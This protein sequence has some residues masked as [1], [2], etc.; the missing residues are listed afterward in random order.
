MP[1]P[2]CNLLHDWLRRTAAERPHAP[3]IEEDEHIT[4]FDQLYRQAEALA[5][6][7]IV[8]GLRPGD[9]VALRLSKTTSAAASVFACLL[10][11]AVY[12]P[13]HP[14]WPQARVQAVLGDCAPRLLIEEE[15]G[16][17]RITDLQTGA[18]FCDPQ[19]TGDREIVADWPRID[20]ASTAV[21][22]FTSG[23][24][25]APKGVVLSHRAVAA[26]VRWTAAE[27]QISS[28]DRIACPAPLG[29]DLSTFDLFN[30]ALT[31]A[32]VVLVPENIAWMPRF[33]ACFVRESRISC[34]YSVPSI[35]SAM[36][37]EGRL[38]ESDYP[39]LRLVLFAGEVFAP[40]TLARLMTAVPHAQCVNLYGPTE[41]NVVT[42]YRVPRT[43]K[44]H[45]PLPIGRSCPYAGTA[46]DQASGELLAGGAS[47]MDGYWNR[48]E[49]TVRAFAVVDGRRYYRTGD[50]VSV[51]EDGNYLFHGRLD[52]QIKRR[53]FRIELGEIEAALMRHPHVIEA[54][55]VA[56]IDST[57]GTRI[58]A[59][60]HLCADSALTLAE[61]RAHCAGLLAPYMLPDH[62][63]F[64]GILVKGNR[65]KI[66][67]AALAQVAEGYV[68][69]D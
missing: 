7:F 28:R 18:V 42:W 20:S 13:I 5:R 63:E 27:F 2:E 4:T 9:R 33:L 32:T 11:G 41:T 10:A 21:I 56:A 22:L 60:V 36:L 45:D 14:R 53:G 29:F 46:I 6:E 25:G 43:F 38:A 67:Y 3:A 57:G 39:H 50:R 8:H 55:V 48:P 26:F 59:F 44:E 34:W 23:S 61:I 69:G 40:P 68:R 24:T 31:G 47:L 66:D 65:G 16:V 64:A 15:N 30:M 58:V 51:A 52:R 54:A 49:E 17:R 19:P 37:E 62:F 35:L 1:A 12:V